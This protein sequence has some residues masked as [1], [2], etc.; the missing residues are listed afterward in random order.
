M[1]DRA[2]ADVVLALALS[3]TS[4][5][6]G[7][8][9]SRGSRAC[10]PASPRPD[11]GVR[12]PRRPDGPAAAGD[13]RGRLPRLHDDGFRAAFGRR[14]RVVEERP[15]AR[16]ARVLF[17]MERRHDDAADD[18]RRAGPPFAV[19]PLRSIR[20][21]P[22]RPGGHPRR[23]SPLVADVALYPIVVGLALLLQLM[24]FN[25]VGF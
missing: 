3:T 21:P 4:R 8:C 14:F 1:L 9:R 5:S 17:R 2:D 19:D 16:H 6:A 10:S 13:P 7:T 15:A 23:R 24:A 18:R 25:G 22:T 12:R 11:R 20:T